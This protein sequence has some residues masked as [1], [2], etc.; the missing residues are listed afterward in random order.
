VMQREGGGFG[1]AFRGGRGRDVSAYG[2]EGCDALATLRRLE[3]LCARVW[4]RWDQHL[5]TSRRGF[6][7]QLHELHDSHINLC[8]T[9]LGD[10]DVI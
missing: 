2:S 1:E 7:L 8:A 5:V 10:D 4:A 6:I 3:A 9:C